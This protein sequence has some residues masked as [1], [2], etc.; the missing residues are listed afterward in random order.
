MELMNRYDDARLLGF[1]K[2]VADVFIQ[3]GQGDMRKVTAPE[4]VRHLKP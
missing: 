4:G 2:L 1:A 3:A